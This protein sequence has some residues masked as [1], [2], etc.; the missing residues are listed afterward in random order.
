MDIAAKRSPW[1]MIEG[2]LLIV[3]GLAALS[4]P[5][6]AG[7]AVALVFGWILI[8]SGLAGLFA[9]FAGREH[10]HFGWSLASAIVALLVGVA[11]L[12][13]PL[14]GAVGL[15]LLLG[16]YLFVDGL[17]LIGLALDQRRRSSA[18]WGWLMFSGVADLVLAV[19][20]VILGASGEAVLIGVI[21]G[22][23]LLVAGVALLL[24]HGAR[25]PLAEDGTPAAPLATL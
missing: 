22:L 24:A 3:L 5:M 16:A 21:V 18:R 6:I 23:D 12:F 15:S 11:I 13:A 17:V 10:V 7:M 9:A 4:A 14:I 19:L 1:L 25:R 20:V 2:L 8:L